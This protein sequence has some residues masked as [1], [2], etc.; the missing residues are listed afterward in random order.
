MPRLRPVFVFAVAI[1]SALL[2]IDILYR[3]KYS[4][5]KKYYKSE[6]SKTCSVCPNSAGIKTG[7]PT[8]RRANAAVVIL[9]RNSDLDGL[10]Q[11]L[12]QFENRFNK[13]YHYPYVFLNEVEFT[14]EFKKGIKEMISS[15]AEFGLIPEDHW[16]YPKWIDVKK[17][18]TA[19][20]KMEKDNIIYG[21][22]L[23]YRHM[24]RYNSGFFFRHP[25]LKTYDFY[26][27][28]EP[29]VDFT[30]DIN[31]DPFLF[32]EDNGKDYGFTIMMPEY[33]ATIPTLWDQTKT[34]MMKYPQYL[35]PRNTLKELFENSDG[36]YNLCHFWSNF[37]IAS[38]KFLRSEA[39][40]KYFEHLDQAGGF[41]YERWGDAPVHSIAAGM[42]LPKEK[43]H[44]FEDIGYIHAPFG[45]CPANPTPSMNCQCDYSKSV[46]T[47]CGTKYNILLNS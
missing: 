33:E 5:A 37:E 11:S 18:D 10:K 26:W 30:C 29:G 7:K 20:A 39:Y 1:V 21:G 47:F 25:L 27:R 15:N 41:F 31:Y 8:E 44:F 19:R 6:D 35:H 23:S 12:P 45:N 4:P 40:M 38:L 32:M 22:S 42:F 46:K 36:D 3:V 13:K 28:V 14:E 34:F 24:C 43:I 17:A 2:F 9:A 16:S